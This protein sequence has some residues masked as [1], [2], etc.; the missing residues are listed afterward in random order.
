MDA[1]GTK[2]KGGPGLLNVTMFLIREEGY[3]FTP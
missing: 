1:V 3:E 2:Y